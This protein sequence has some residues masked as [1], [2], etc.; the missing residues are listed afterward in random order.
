[1]K[2]IKN[3]IIETIGQNKKG[4][5]FLLVLVVFT[6]LIMIFNKTDIFNNNVNKIYKRANY[7]FT[8]ETEKI[9]DTKTYLPYVNLLG[10]DAKKVNKDLKLLY[11]TKN[12]LKDRY[13][14]YKYYISDDILTLIVKLYDYKN[15]DFESEIYF[16]NFSINNKTLLSNEVLKEM[17]NISEDDIKNKINSYL[18]EYYNYEIEKEYINPDLCDINCYIDFFEDKNSQNI[19]LYVKDN[20]LYAYKKYFIDYKF[21]YDTEKPFEDIY[22]F[23]LN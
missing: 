21:A 23:K 12:I 10:D 2:E 13:M 5:I 20:K 1:M 3:S 22:S 16:Y 9:N 14:T 7:I 15:S 8:E 6:I 17:F 4:T 19:K 11:Y 18:K